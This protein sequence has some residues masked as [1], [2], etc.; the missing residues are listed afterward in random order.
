MSSIAS[1][2]FTTG[3]SASLVALR[4][5]RPSSRGSSSGAASAEAKR[6]R[7]RSSSFGPACHG[8]SGYSSRTI[9]ADC[10]SGSASLPSSAETPPKAVGNGTLS[11]LRTSSWNSRAERDASLPAVVL[12]VCC[13]TMVSHVATFA[14][15]GRGAAV[16]SA[17][18]P[19]GDSGKAGAAARLSWHLRATSVRHGSGRDADLLVWQPIATAH[20]RLT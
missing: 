1:T 7:G 17:P 8:P 3:L 12:T 4:L 20:S 14:R 16:P 15:G 11:R 2:F 18:A 9:E 19:P 6:G 13:S 5:A 10:A